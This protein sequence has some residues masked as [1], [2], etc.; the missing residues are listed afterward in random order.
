MASQRFHKRRFHL[1][2]C[3]NT[4]GFQN[5]TGLELSATTPSESLP[6]HNEELDTVPEICGSSSGT[7]MNLAQQHASFICRFSRWW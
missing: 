1:L 3:K 2:F 4:V 5:K 7:T 6:V